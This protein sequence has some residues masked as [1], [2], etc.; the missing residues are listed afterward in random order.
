LPQRGFTPIFLDPGSAKWSPDGFV[1][2][3]RSPGLPFGIQRL[4]SDMSAITNSLC[5]QAPDLLRTHGIDGIVTD[6]MEPAGA[7]VAGFLHLPYVSLAAA[8][9]I[10]REP[11]VPLPV[12]PWDYEESEWGLK[13]NRAGEQIA[14]WLTR[15]HD[16]TI[17]QWSERF[18]IAR[19]TKLVECL[20]PLADMSQMIRGLDFPRSHLP[21]SFHHVGRLRPSES[22]AS[23]QLPSFGPAPLVYASL[24]TLQGHRLGLFRRI[25]KAC[26]QLGLQLLISHSGSLT[27]EEAQTIDADWVLPWVPQEAVLKRANIVITHGGL[28]TVLDALAEGLPLLCLPLAFEQP[29]IGARIERSGAGIVLGARSPAPKIAVALERLLNQASF[30]QKAGALAQELARSPGS[31]GAAVIVEQVMQTR[32]PVLRQRWPEVA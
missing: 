12:L 18:A 1:A 6:Q 28:N 14:D 21:A 4:V 17:Q 15:R 9:P 31:A 3:S 22:T 27:P 2:H 11:L 32:Q 5:E 10:N 19:R 25:A 20:S 29:G 16:Q 13:R 7:L 23:G 26:R 8:A 30:R 24:G